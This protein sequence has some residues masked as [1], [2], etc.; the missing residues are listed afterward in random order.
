M[1]FESILLAYDY[2]TTEY[3]ISS[4]GSFGV[5]YTNVS[6]QRVSE[7]RPTTGFIDQT[8]DI[9]T[10]MPSPNTAGGGSASLTANAPLVL[11]VT[12]ASPTAGNGVLHAK[13]IYRVIATGL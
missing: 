3:T 8:A 9:I 13:V 7:T 4:S 2:G 6:G 5:Y 12:T 1:Q 10:L 11:C